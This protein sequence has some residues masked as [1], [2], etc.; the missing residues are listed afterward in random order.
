MRTLSPPPLPLQ[1]SLASAD[2][3]RLHQGVGILLLYSLLASVQD[4]FLGNLFQRQHPIVVLV[5]TC[6]LAQI[7]LLSFQVRAPR[8]YLAILRQH[9]RTLVLL[10]SATAMAWIGFYSSL[11]YLEP[12][13][14]STFTFAIGPL[15]IALLG[16]YFRPEHPVSRSEMRAA[17]GI[18]SGLVVLA[19]SQYR[20]WSGLGETPPVDSLRGLGLAVIGGMGGAGI[21]LFSKRLYDAGVN[22]VTIMGSRLFGVLLVGLLL[23]P[24]EWTLQGSSLNFALTM[25]AL[26]VF[27]VGA[28]IFLLQLGIERC[29]PITAAIIVSVIPCITYLLQVCDA[30]ISASIPTLVGVFICV[31]FVALGARSRRTAQSTPGAT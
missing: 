14:G 3:R 21:K 23:W 18:F 16:G 2:S 9:W 13:I 25:L 27:A 15:L 5:C 12:A 29:E 26:T 24:S 28:P 7:F 11:R 10:N 19:L 8:A 1:R 4:V 30:R 20:G 22:V 17:F 31:A 6:S